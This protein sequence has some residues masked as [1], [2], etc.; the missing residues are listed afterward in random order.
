VLHCLL[1][2]LLVTLAPA[3]NTW[4]LRGETLHFVLLFLVIPLSVSALGIG[5]LKHRRIALV[6]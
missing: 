3:L 2:P 1:T 5:F 4:F 6:L